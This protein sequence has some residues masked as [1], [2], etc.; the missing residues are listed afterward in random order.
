MKRMAGSVS[1]SPLVDGLQA[2]ARRLFAL[3]RKF[4]NVEPYMKV[5]ITE[6]EK[7]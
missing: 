7:N 1:A 3:N 5:Q 4:A 6:N 2:I